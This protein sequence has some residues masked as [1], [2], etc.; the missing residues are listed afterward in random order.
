MSV[1]CGI[2]GTEYIIKIKIHSSCEIDDFVETLYEYEASCK[3][4]TS[5]NRSPCRAW[6][7]L[8]TVLY[9][10]V[11]ARKRKVHP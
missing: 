6:R 11:R 3:V 1:T 8:V 2:P 10:F 7:H 5:G 9:G 4:R